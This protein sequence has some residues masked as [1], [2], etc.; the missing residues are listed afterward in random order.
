MSR[1]EFGEALSRAAA[2]SPSW[3]LDG[4]PRRRTP[5]RGELSACADAIDVARLVF[6]QLDQTGQHSKREIGRLVGVARGTVD[7]ALE[8]DRLPKYQAGGDRLECQSHEELGVCVSLG[9][10]KR[11]SSR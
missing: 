7:R 8:A 4:T 2:G 9:F 1:S 11:S 5:G 6:A 10:R 3:I